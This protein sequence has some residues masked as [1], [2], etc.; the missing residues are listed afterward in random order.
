MKKI[1]VNFFVALGVIFFIL[2]IIASYLFVVDPYN[3]KP[4]IFGTS[5]LQEKTGQAPASTT[6]GDNGNVETINP[7]SGF[8][9]SEA[10]KQALI[11]LGLNPATVPSTIDPKQEACFVEVLGKTRVEEIKSGAVP[12]AIEFVKAK[13][14]I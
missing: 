6:V 9:L 12:G 11:N 10:Q 3:L 4:L 2:I 1:L 8:V 7:D 14:C 5:V 13:A